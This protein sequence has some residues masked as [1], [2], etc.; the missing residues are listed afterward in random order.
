MAEIRFENINEQYAYMIRSSRRSCKKSPYGRNPYR[1]EYYV[2]NVYDN[3]KPRPPHVKRARSSN[4]YSSRPLLRVG[5]V[6]YTEFFER[7][8]RA[9]ERAKQFIEN[10][11]LIKKEGE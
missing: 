7:K 3:S 10:P 5:R 9:E 6:V 1:R 2:L 4:N 11:Q 8:E